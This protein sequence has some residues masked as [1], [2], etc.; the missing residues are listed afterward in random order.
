MF[1]GLFVSLC[2]FLL[3]GCTQRV[4]KSRPQ[5]PVTVAH[6]VSEE[7]EQENNTRKIHTRI[8]R[9]NPATVVPG[10]TISEKSVPL[11]QDL[12]SYYK[13]DIAPNNIPTCGQYNICR[14][15]NERFRRFMQAIE[16]N[17]DIIW[18]I[19]GGYGTSDLIPLLD[20]IPV[21]ECS[22]T[23]IGFSDITSL[24][25]FMARKWPHWRAIHASVLIHAVK[26]AHINDKFNTLLNILEGKVSKYAID[27]LYPLNAKAKTKQS[28]IGRL[29]GGNLSVVVNSLGKIWEIQSMGKI[30]FLEDVN[31]S[32]DGI[33]SALCHLKENCKFDGVSA[34][35]FGRFSIPDYSQKE[36]VNR[37]EEFAQSLE[38]PVYFTHKFG[39]GN[40]NQPLIYNA[41]AIIK[42]NKM[43]IDA[44]TCVDLI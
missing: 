21:P 5:P 26:H 29:T 8:G 32:I 31:L 44:T 11:M 42:D 36:I 13:I 35:V 15:V 16:S 7:E 2:L 38:I 27:N 22:K 18:A 37:L 43:T 19:R 4:Q 41:I 1:V 14:P 30:M 23:L 34:L 17:Q 12:A 9:L 10:R 28:V 6:A 24:H 20:S 33:E 25:L 3:P 40:V 39:H